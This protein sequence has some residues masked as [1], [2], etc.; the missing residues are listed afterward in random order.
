MAEAP[1]ELVVVQLSAE[2]FLL[3][4]LSLSFNVC[5]IFSTISDGLLLD[6]PL[7]PR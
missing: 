5:K 7:R 6:D 2:F 1:S 4:S 3:N